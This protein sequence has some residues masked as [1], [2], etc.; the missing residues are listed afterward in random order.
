MLRFRRTPHRTLTYETCP[1]SD[2]ISFPGFGLV[3][4]PKSGYL[5]L[6]PGQRL[7]CLGD[8]HGDFSVLQHMLHLA[9]VYD[10]SASSPN[11]IG[12]DTVVVQCGDIMDRGPQELACW[13]LLSK[14][15]QQAATEGGTVTAL[16][17]NHEVMN[18][19]GLFHY[20]QGGDKEFEHYLGRPFD[21]VVA[22][23]SDLGRTWRSQFAGNQPARWAACEPG[24]L[25]AHTLFQHLSVALVVGRTLCVH[26][27]LTVQHLQDYS[28]TNSNGNESG[29]PGKSSDNALAALNAAAREW[30]TTAHHGPNANVLPSNMSGDDIIGLAN[31]RTRAASRALPSCLGGGR[32]EAESP[33]WLRL[34]SS[35]ADDE[36]DKTP[37]DTAQEELDAVLHHLSASRMAMGHT[38][39]SRLNV[40]LQQK[41]WRLDTAASRGMGGGCVEVLEIVHGESD[42]DDIVHIIDTAGQRIP[43]AERSRG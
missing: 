30:I 35:P 12:G 40:A 41:A 27:G 11:W 20:T 18:A 1:L 22:V 37:N 4:P 5:P 28:S 17:G 7:I 36:E 3:P 38:P 2:L 32:G 31:I 43:G 39:Q 9:G 34:Y 29:N 33:V 24:G 6:R 10:P 42:D 15:S 21:H 26:A 14:L 16:W 25:L 23:P 19:L 13:A 8:V